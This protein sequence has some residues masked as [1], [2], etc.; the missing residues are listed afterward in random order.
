MSILG[1]LSFHNSIVFCVCL[2]FTGVKVWSF[3]QSALNAAVEDQNPVANQARTAAPI[4]VVSVTFGRMTWASI[5][6]A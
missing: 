4:A 3:S 1:S 2:S 6:L 5:K